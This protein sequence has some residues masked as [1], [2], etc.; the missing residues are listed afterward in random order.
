M[1]VFVCLCVHVSVCEFVCVFAR[2]CFWYVCVRVCTCVLCVFLRVCFR[3]DASVYVY[4][5]GLFVSHYFVESS[6]SSYRQERR[7]TNG[8][9]CSRHCIA[10][11]SQS[12]ARLLILYI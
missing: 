8:L 10:T 2:V 3:V 9:K 12:T 4:N 7:Q 1:R 11:Y 6:H 5:L